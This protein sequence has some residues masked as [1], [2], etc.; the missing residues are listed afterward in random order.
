MSL[1]RNQ[2]RTPTTPLQAG[3]KHGVGELS[4]ANGDKYSGDFAEGKMHGWGTYKMTNGDT[5]DGEFVQGCMTGSGTYYYA[6]GRAVYRSL[7]VL[8]LRQS[9]CSCFSLPLAFL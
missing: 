9:T 5:Y 2:I 3:L 1:H 6:D 8:Y 7:H 4:L